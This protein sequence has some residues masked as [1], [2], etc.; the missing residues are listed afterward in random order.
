MS[1]LRAR[2][3]FAKG[4]LAGVRYLNPLGVRR[5]IGDVTLVPVPPLVRPLLRVAFW[6]VF[7]YLLTPERRHVEI[8]PDGA[9]RLVA[10]AVDEVSPEY[11]I[12]VADE[13]VMAMPLANAEV[14]VEAVRD[15]VPGDLSPAHS[16]LEAC[17]VG[18]G[19]ARG[20]HQR[21]IARVQ[22]DKVG[23]LVRPE[24]T[25]NAGM[26]RPAMDA[27][28]EEGAVDNQLTA[29]FEQIEQAY[30]TRGSV[31]LVRFL[32]SHPRHPPAFGSHGVT[33]ADQCL[34]LHEQLFPRGVPFLRG[35][36]RRR[37]HRKRCTFLAG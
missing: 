23:D 21:C 2:V 35:Y 8:A 6:G 32:D 9:H 18:L 24:R 26:L 15:G 17:N 19:R 13:R 34:F 29:T 31:E 16:S 1:C 25:A 4:G 27:G 22:V 33:G 11:A 14:G 30:P 36:D 3:A 7:P 37:V 5:G 10:A 20:V 28:L 12:A